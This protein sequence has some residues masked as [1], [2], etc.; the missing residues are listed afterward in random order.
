M[1]VRPEGWSAAGAAATNLVMTR[2]GGASNM[3]RQL[4]GEVGRWRIED[5]T[6]IAQEAAATAAAGVRQEISAGW[7]PRLLLDIDGVQ[8]AAP[9]D[10]AL[11][12]AGTVV[13][14]ASGQEVAIDTLRCWRRSPK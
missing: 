3:L 12:A 8:A 4:A 6:N 2:S 14:Q 13:L 9:Y 7:G 5:G 11:A 1:G 10:G